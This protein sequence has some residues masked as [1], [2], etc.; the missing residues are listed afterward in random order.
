[1][2]H[3]SLNT[4]SLNIL[5]MGLLLYKDQAKCRD[6]FKLNNVSNLEFIT[7]LYVTELSF[8]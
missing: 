4:N 8:L 2:S 1:M 6:W 7:E 3:V 5:R